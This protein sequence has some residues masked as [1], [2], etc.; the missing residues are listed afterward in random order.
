MAQYV[1]KQTLTLHNNLYIIIPKHVE[2]QAL[3][4]LCEFPFIVYPWCSEQ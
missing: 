3:P 1:H 4:K 2:L